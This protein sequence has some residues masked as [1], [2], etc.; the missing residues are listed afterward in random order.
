VRLDLG[1]RKFHLSA[2]DRSKKTY[3]LWD[4]DWNRCCVCFDRTVSIKVD[5]RAVGVTTRKAWSRRTRAV[6]VS[7]SSEVYMDNCFSVRALPLVH[8]GLG[9]N[10]ERQEQCHYGKRKLDHSLHA[11]RLYQKQLPAR[12]RC[13]KERMAFETTDVHAASGPHW[14][15]AFDAE[16]VFSTA[17]SLAY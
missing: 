3:R 2:E 1:L 7:H 14:I 9:P 10:H 15:G 6:H 12:E 5:C 8:M 11:P 13:Q 17:G 4:E 16:Y